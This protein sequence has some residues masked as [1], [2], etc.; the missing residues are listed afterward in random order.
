MPPRVYLT[1]EQKWQAIGMIQAGESQ[2]AVARFFGKSKSVISRLVLLHRQNG[3]VT[4]RAGRGRPC[5]TTPR[6]DRRIRTIA[7]RNRFV[8]APELKRDILA[9]TGTRISTSTI[10]R[11]LHLSGL[12][13]RRPMRGV[14]MTAAHR[15]LRL[16]WARQHQGRGLRHWR[17]VMFTDESRFCLRF[18]DGRK[19]VWRRRG[20]RLCRDT[21]VEHDSYGG[22]SVMVWG[23]ISYDRRTDL[24]MIPGNVTGQRYVDEIL[25]PHVIPMA[26]RVGPNFEFQDDNARPHRAHVAVNFLAQHGVVSLPWPAK[27]PDLN[28]IEHLWDIL[29]RCVRALQPQPADLPQLAAALQQEW[30]RLP[31]ETIRRLIRSMPSRCR[32]CIDARGG[33]TKY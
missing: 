9:A 30:R 1:T 19:R 26:N 29:G 6:E 10:R 32:C 33:H 8:T 15:R 21:I 7:L 14:K 22:G 23:G 2:N 31:R 16:Q 13:S 20:E 24:V 17:Y 12:K 4:M 28:P 27:S 25:R 5:K 3:S 18:T 11:R